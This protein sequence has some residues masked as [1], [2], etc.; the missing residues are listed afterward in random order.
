MRRMARSN[1]FGAKFVAHAG[2][3]LRART[4]SVAQFRS[5]RCE[6]HAR[7]S[8]GR[9]SAIRPGPAIGGLPVQPGA[10]AGGF[11]RRHALRQQPAD[12]PASTSPAPA[13][14]SQGGAVSLIAAR[15]S[16]AATI[17]SAPFSSTT[18]PVRAA[19][20]RTAARRSAPGC[21]EHAREL[22]G[23][24]GQHAAPRSRSGAPAQAVS[25]SASTTTARPAASSSRQRG[26]GRHRPE[27]RPA[28]PHCAPAHRP[29][30]CASGRLIDDGARARR[31]DTRSALP[32]RGDGDHAGA[33]RRR[34]A[35]AASRAAPVMAAPPS[36]VTWPR[37]YL[38]PVRHRCR[39]AATAADGCRTCA[40][41][42]V[43]RR[44]GQA[45]I[46][47]HRLAAQ[48]APRQQQVPRLAAGRT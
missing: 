18:A 29:A 30:A 27:A 37:E 45:D 19:A 44:I 6:S 8:G 7:Q 47:Q 3:P 12:Q 40:A 31:R 38:W 25:A 14:A 48:R 41:H 16:G 33:A 28:H 26:R 22:A 20:A 10:G 17:V 15:P 46:R 1:K 23:V 4:R 9:S 34:A 36:T 13:V 42:R 43:Q 11:P 5:R 24:R 21:A 2:V 32:M 39:A 35:T